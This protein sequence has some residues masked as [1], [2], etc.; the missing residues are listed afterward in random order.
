MLTDS[1]KPILLL[2]CIHI[3]IQSNGQIQSCVIIHSYFYKIGI[4]KFQIEK[5]NISVQSQEHCKI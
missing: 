2:D 1:Q 5:D 3:D 4:H